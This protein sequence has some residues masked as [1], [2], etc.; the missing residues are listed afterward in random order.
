MKHDWSLRHEI[1]IATHRW[2]IILL[3]GLIGVLLAWIISFIFPS[4]YRATK[5]LYVGINIIPTAQ[6][7]DPAGIS[8]LTFTNADDF[9]NWQ[10]ANL[11]SSVKMDRVLEITLQRLQTM[12]RYWEAVTVEELNH[13]LH[14]YWRNAG[15]WR[16]VAE[17][18]DP[19]RAEQAILIW[20]E[21]VVENIH[22][23]IEAA[24]STMLLELQL[25]SIIDLQN[26]L[27]IYIIEKSQSRE[28]LEG[29]QI[30]AAQWPAQQAIDSTNRLNLETLLYQANSGAAWEKILAA[31]P[32]SQ[33]SSQE[34]VT[35]L[36]I[37]IS[38]LD[39]EILT[40]Q[41]QTRTLEKNKNDTLSKYAATSSN[42]LGLSSNLI[43]DQ[44]TD[45]P[46]QITSVRPSGALILVGG[47]LGII[48]W[49]FYW[50]SGI[51]I[52]RPTNTEPSQNSDA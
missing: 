39:K 23:A 7:I 38:A 20:E 18:P 41:N 50:I 28:L 10:M 19:L 42:S 47:L 22:N 32:S 17:H 21:V 6:D 26:E 13:M 43:V 29:W 30:E 40:L 46:A 37:T 31:F 16:L 14:V 27:E 45:E 15:K 33:A 2:P 24:Q 12:D 4:Q 36:N 49:A 48:I 9:K 11:D 25:R 52:Q 8:R 3:S 35:F 34:Y 44:V 51:V 1:L 5:E